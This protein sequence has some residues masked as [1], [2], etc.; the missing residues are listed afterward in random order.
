MT[1]CLL[2]LS[3]SSSLSVDV[4]EEL[5]APRSEISARFR[6]HDVGVV[7]P[8]Y[9]PV[10]HQRLQMPAYLALRQIGRHG[11]VSLPRPQLPRLAVEV[12]QDLRRRCLLI[13]CHPVHLRPSSPYALPKH[14]Y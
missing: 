6:P 5:D 14:S 3:E 7:V 4:V 12:M 1:V 8:R 13:R 11:D 2:T 9:D 10:I